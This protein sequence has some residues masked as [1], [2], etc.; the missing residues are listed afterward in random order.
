MLWELDRFDKEGGAW[1][2]GPS[3]FRGLAV[4]LP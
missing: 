2:E 4:F 3:Y 1:L